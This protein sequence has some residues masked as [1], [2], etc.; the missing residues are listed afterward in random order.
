MC[1]SNLLLYCFKESLRNTVSIY[2]Y[3]YTGNS[4]YTTSVGLAQARPNEFNIIYFMWA[5]K[6]AD[7]LSN[8]EIAKLIYI[9]VCTSMAGKYGILDTYPNKRFSHIIK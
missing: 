2:I 8:K 7:F 3:L 1:I 9:T 6:L 5:V 4:D